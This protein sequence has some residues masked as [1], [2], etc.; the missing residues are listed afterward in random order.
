MPVIIG[1]DGGPV[2]AIIAPDLIRPCK[3]QQCVGKRSDNALDRTEIFL[4]NLREFRKKIRSQVLEIRTV[5]ARQY[6]RFERVRSEIRAQRQEI[7]ILLDD[8]RGRLSPF[9]LRDDVTK[10]ASFFHL[11]MLPREIE[12]PADAFGNRRRCYQGGMRMHA[13]AAG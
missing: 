4:Q 3:E 13:L 2:T 12:F 9:L 8:T 10:Q 11:K 7:F 1:I 6:P 5:L